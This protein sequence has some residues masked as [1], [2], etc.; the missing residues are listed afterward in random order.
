MKIEKNYIYVLYDP[1]EPD[2]Y[3]YVGFTNNI[4]RRLKA[5]FDEVKKYNKCPELFKTYK[6]NWINSLLNENIKPEMKII[7]EF[8]CDRKTIGEKEIYYGEKFLNEGHK[9]TNTAEFGYCGNNFD[10]MSIEQKNIRNKKISSALKG[11]HPSNETKKMISEKLKNRIIS[12]E[13]KQ[14]LS[15]LYKNKKRSIDT[16]NKIKK[17]CKPNIKIIIHQF[18]I[19]NIYIE[20]YESIKYASDKT[21]ICTSSIIHCCKGRYKTAGGFV[22]K[23]KENI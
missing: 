10:N 2:N 20:E 1:R 7:E 23:Y 8:L 19:N 16:I 6:I 13:H 18:D 21:G 11:K 22:W 15:I 3:R 12:E 17:N 5:H 14:K 4:K 9:L